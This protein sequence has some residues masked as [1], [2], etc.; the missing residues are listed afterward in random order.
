MA[1]GKCG[2]LV[3]DAEGNRSWTT[4]RGARRIVERGLGEESNGILRMREADLRYNS[5]AVAAHSPRLASTA[6]PFRY[7]WLNSEAAVLR[8]HSAP[9]V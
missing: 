9:A 1:H 3:L 4:K 5:P 7:C 2:V 6:L 8:F